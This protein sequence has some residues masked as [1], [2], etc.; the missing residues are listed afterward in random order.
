MSRNKKL[1][2]RIK[3]PEKLLGRL[4]QRSTVLRQCIGRECGGE[5]CLYMHGLENELSQ[6]EVVNDRLV[7][8]LLSFG[9]IEKCGEDFILSPAGRIALR[10]QV[11]NDGECLGQH[12]QRQLKKV[13]IGPTQRV[14][15][16]NLNESPLG[17][18]YTRKDK[19]GR[20]FLELYQFESGERLRADF[21]RGCRP[22]KITADWDAFAAPRNKGVVREACGISAT[23]HAIIARQ[24][25][26]NAINAV[27]PE[28][29]GI[30]IDICCNQTGIEDAEKK[31]GWPKRSGKII[32]RIALTRLAR[33]YGLLAKPC[34][35]GAPGG[36]IRHWGDQNFR[37]TI[38]GSQEASIEELN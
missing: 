31:N 24:R 22:Q 17:W 32:L 12:Q 14:A 36:K 38:D 10:R 35:D 9:H 30:L 15:T 13:D 34:N 29:S 28:L 6:Q 2:K 5:W 23:D 7:Q 37:P 11:T 3:C 4:G 8:G 26:T 18:L 1:S 21:E 19:A 33:H 20:P 27:G 16:V 25:V